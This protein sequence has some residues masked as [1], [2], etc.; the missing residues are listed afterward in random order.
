MIGRKLLLAALTLSVLPLGGCDETVK[1]KVLSLKATIDSYVVLDAAEFS[2]HLASGDDFVVMITTPG[3][4]SCHEAKRHLRTYIQETGNIVYTV[5]FGE[6]SSLMSEFKVLPTVTKTPTFLFF[7]GGELLKKIEGVRE[8]YADFK[9]L[10]ARY[11]A[12]VPVYT[13]NGYDRETS[14]SD[15]WYIENK[16]DTAM[17][18]SVTGSAGNAKSATVFYTWLRCGDCQNLHRSLFDDYVTK[19][20]PDQPVYLYEVDYLRSRKPGTKPEAGAE[21]YDDYMNWVNFCTKFGFGFYRDGKVPALVNYENGAVVDVAVF[22]N[23]GDMKKNEDGTWS[24]E[25]TFYPEVAALKAESA[26]ALQKEAE[27]IELTKIHKFLND[28]V[29]GA[30]L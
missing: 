3:C 22:A 2:Y 9:A 16:S 27:K 5:D 20:A 14:S 13:L 30:A 8:D 10:M 15:F 25:I 29:R 12:D 17:L 11:V 1:T 19:L 23:D 6:Y 7:K 21:G 4:L 26:V 28:Y 18:E 24:Y